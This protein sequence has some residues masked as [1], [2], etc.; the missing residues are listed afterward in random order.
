MLGCRVS[1][2]NPYVVEKVEKVGMG[3]GEIG[4]MRV[5]DSE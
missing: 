3:K 5:W 4:C 2:C 1:E